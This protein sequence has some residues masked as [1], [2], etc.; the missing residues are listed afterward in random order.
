MLAGAADSTGL[1]IQAGSLRWEELG[2]SCCLKCLHV[3]FPGRQSQSSQTSYFLQ[4]K[5]AKKTRWKV[6]DLYDLALEAI[7]HHSAILLVESWNLPK[8]KEREHTAHFGTCGDERIG[9][10]DI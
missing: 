5:P 1:D 6:H 8:V 2:W 10:Q 9:R 3:A 4:S 7:E